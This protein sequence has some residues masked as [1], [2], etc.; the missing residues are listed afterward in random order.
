[1]KNNNYNMEGGFCFLRKGK[2]CKKKTINPNS[3]IEGKNFLIM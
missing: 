3:C 2:G 1:M